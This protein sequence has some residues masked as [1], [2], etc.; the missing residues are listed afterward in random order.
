[1]DILKRFNLQEEDLEELCGYSEDQLSSTNLPYLL[2]DIRQK[3]AKRSS[4]ASQS[5][6]AHQTHHR[7]PETMTG[8]G[9][10]YD[11]AYQQQSKVIEYGHTTSQRPVPGAITTNQKPGPGAGTTSQRPAP[12]TNPGAVP[13]PMSIPMNQLPPPVSDSSL[14]MPLP[15]KPSSKRTPTAAMISDY[16]GATPKSFPHTCCLCIKPCDG[17]KDWLNHKQHIVHR[18]SCKLLCKQYSEWEPNTVTLN[19]RSRTRSLSN[20]SSPHHHDGKT[21]YSP[22]RRSRRTSGSPRRG[23]ESPSPRDTQ[24]SRWWSQSSKQTRRS[25]S[26]SRSPHPPSQSRRSRSQSHERSPGHR[27]EQT[28][29]EEL[30][31]KLLET[32]GVQT[33]TG[34]T[35]LEVVVQSLAPVLLAELAKR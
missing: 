2:R 35:S 25:R 28:G 15:A 9:A 23:R 18:A 5:S 20:S 4:S 27:P 29:V 22:T 8:P 32:S 6:M 10:K 1:M 11:P 17:M 7:A 33:S 34:P 26:G 31:R 21:S 12:G 3:K 16:M 14:Q 24:N 13:G 30:A 19:R